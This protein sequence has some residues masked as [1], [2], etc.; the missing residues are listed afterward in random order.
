MALSVVAL[1]TYN[2]MAA[3][4]SA[5]PSNPPDNNV[6]PPI[7]VGVVDQAKYASIRVAGNTSNLISDNIVLAMNH[8]RSV[9]G[10]CDENGLNCISGSSIQPLPTCADGKILIAQAGG[11]ICGDPGY[12]PAPAVWLVNN[13]HTESQCTSLSGTVVAD[14]SNK[15]CRF[16]GGSCPSGWAPYKNWTETNPGSGNGCTYCT[17]ASH[18]WSNT[19][20]ETC[21]YS[22]EYRAC[23][24][25]TGPN[26]DIRC[27]DTNAPAKA[28]ITKI[29]CY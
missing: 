28:I 22:A 18:G 11:W 24:I 8:M 9:G 3:D 10:Y 14:G 17:T 6:P 23:G 13:Q 21:S 19:A 2:F 5:A 15:F 25:D 12:A 29:G 26:C 16:N 1:L 4:W 27:S 7:N 20:I